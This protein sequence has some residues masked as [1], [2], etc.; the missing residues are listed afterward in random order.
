M[1]TRMAQF[2][3]YK[4][5]ASNNFPD[6]TW[7]RYCT[8]E[9]FKKYSPIISLG[10]QTIP[11]TKFYL[12]S[13]LKPIIVGNSGIFELDVKNTSATINNI[14]IDQD[15]MELLKNL[16]NGYLIIDIVYEEQKEMNV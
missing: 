15:S 7:T 13:S 3:Y 8:S 4:D 16:P 9:S 10:I 12:N 5:G 6:W 14:R 1:A 2:R 11:G